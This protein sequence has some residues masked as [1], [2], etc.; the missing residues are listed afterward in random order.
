MF[1]PWRKTDYSTKQ[2]GGINDESQQNNDDYFGGC[3]SAF[4]YGLRSADGK[5]EHLPE[6]FQ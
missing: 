2:T 1:F 4:M 6:E 3:V 5:R